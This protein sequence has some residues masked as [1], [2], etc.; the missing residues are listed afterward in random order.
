MRCLQ[1][2]AVIGFVMVSVAWAGPARSGSQRATSA[3]PSP[4]TVHQ[5]VIRSQVEVKR[6]ERNLTRQESHRKQASKRLQQ[7][8]QAIAKLQEQLHELQAGPSGGPH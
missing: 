8:D 5:R 3:A 7:Q 1:L 6:L 4:S 2:I